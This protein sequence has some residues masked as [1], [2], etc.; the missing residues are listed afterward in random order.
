MACIFWCCS[1]KIRVLPMPGFDVKKYMGRWYEIARLRHPFERGL[2]NVTADYTLQKN[3]KIRVANRGF[4]PGRE[5]WQEARAVAVEGDAPNHLKVYFFPL[6]P[7]HYKVAYLD[8]EY[9]YAVVSG[10]H[11]EFLWFLARTPQISREQ[12]NK[13]LDAARRLGYDT[14]KLIYVEHTRPAK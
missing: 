10:G 3:G 9:R 14:D 1:K 8:P 2:T 4:H 5:K 7:G 6:I 11:P 13:M 12:L